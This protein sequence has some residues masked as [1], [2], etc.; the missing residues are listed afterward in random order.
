MLLMICAS[1][2]EGKCE[3]QDSQTAISTL[4][5]NVHLINTYAVGFAFIFVLFFQLSTLVP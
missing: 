1:V 5:N 2:T 4:G 3:P